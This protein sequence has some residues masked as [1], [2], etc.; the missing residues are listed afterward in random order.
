MRSDRQGL[1]LLHR[2]ETN[3]GYR[4]NNP[5]TTG[6][7]SL[8]RLT[9][10]LRF[11]ASNSLRWFSQFT[12]RNHGFSNRESC[13]RRSLQNEQI[14]CHSV[15]KP[16]RQGGN[17]ARIEP[18]QYRRQCCSMVTEGQPVCTG[19]TYLRHPSGKHPIRNEGTSGNY[20]ANHPMGV[21]N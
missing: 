6:G 17:R 9:R 16:G 1:G 5:E 3:F 19:T 8:T 18:E 21:P 4:R 2:H 14:W 13:S 20:C 11:K 7:N 10:D 15:P 12:R